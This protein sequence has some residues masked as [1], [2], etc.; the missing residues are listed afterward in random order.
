VL[1]KLANGLSGTW[2]SL[3][4]QERI[5]VLYGLACVVFSISFALGAPARAEKKRSEMRELA[6]MVAERLK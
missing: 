2:E 3:D 1:S 4:P 5:L 6:D